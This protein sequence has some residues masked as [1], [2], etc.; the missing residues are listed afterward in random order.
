MVQGVWHNIGAVFIGRVDGDW[1]IRT[2]TRARPACRVLL[3]IL[4]MILVVFVLGLLLSGSLL[5]LL[6][7]PS[8]ES[9]LIMLA[10]RSGPF[11]TFWL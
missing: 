11:S 3:D 7:A 6:A 9:V 1:P 10:T 4:V 5:D 8:V 2:R